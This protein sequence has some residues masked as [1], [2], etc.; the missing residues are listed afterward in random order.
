MDDTI[1]SIL[2]KVIQ[3]TR[4]N[5]E[6]NTE[7]R[8]ELEIAP[9][10]KSV[11][12]NE[13]K[14]EHIYEYCIEKILKKQAE[15]F[16][17][18]FP[19]KSITTSLVKDYVR[20]EGFRRKD[21]FGDFCLALYQQIECITNCICENSKLNQ[22]AEKMWGQSAYVKSGAGIT[23]SINN[24]SESSFVVAKLVFFKDP[25][26]KSQSAL[27]AQAALDKIR[28]VVYFLG[29]KCQMKNSD[30]DS[31]VEITTLLNYIYQCRNT[32]HRGN[33]PSDWEQ[34]TLDKVLPFRSFYYFKFLGVLAQYVA[35]VKAGFEKLDEIYSS[36]STLETKK[37]KPK[38]PNIIGKIDLSTIPKR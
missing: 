14:L 11:S 38:G 2:H 16:Y 17:Q 7:L 26:K 15:E 18:S 10:A 27:Q 22:I 12:I 33:T 9:S 1:K 13:G 8:K 23:P 31:Y 37:V 20:M 6:F 36:T 29:Y 24:R 35:F 19:M 32:N 5:P 34:K 25:E 4:Q 30:Y 3:L 28:A 21:A